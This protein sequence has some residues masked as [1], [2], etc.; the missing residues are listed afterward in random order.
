MKGERRRRLKI[1]IEGS[2]KD[3]LTVFKTVLKEI[4]DGQ[5]RDLIYNLETSMIIK[6]SKSLHGATYKLLKGE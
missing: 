2:E 3:K 4:P 5:L 6:L 1:V